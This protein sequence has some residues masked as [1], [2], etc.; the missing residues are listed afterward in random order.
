MHD[1]FLLSS[2][3]RYHPR[4]CI[5]ELQFPSRTFP[6]T[7]NAYVNCT[8]LSSFLSWFPSYSRTTNKTQRQQHPRPLADT[9]KICFLTFVSTR[10]RNTRR[11]FECTQI[12]YEN[13]S[14]VNV[15]H[16]ATGDNRAATGEFQNEKR[17]ACR[18]VFSLSF[19]TII[20][21]TLHPARSTENEKLWPASKRLQCLNPDDA[22]RC[23]IS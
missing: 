12:F 9:E 20:S 16:V 22:E 19:F 2:F 4:V 15:C 11:N 1:A 8:L 13:V 17:F 23:W 6:G 10:E 5:G 21:A 3:S 7:S 14:S 18:S